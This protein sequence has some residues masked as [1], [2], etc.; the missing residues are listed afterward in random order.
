M[1]LKEIMK[2]ILKLSDV[3]GE[4]VPLKLLCSM[5]GLKVPR[6]MEAYE[7]LPPRIAFSLAYRDK[8]MKTLLKEVSLELIKE[9]LRKIEVS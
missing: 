3:E 8:E 6:E 7:D 5:F 2:L 4:D 9:K 1:E